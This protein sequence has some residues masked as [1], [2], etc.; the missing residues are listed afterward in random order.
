MPDFMLPEVQ[1]AAWTIVVFVLLAGLLWKFAWGP[2]LKA[3][4]ERED[5]ITKKLQDAEDKLKAAEARVADYERKIAGSKEEAAAIIAEGKRDVEKVRDEILAAAQ[6]E[7]AKTLERVKTEIRLAQEAAMQELRQKVSQWTAEIASKVIER[8]IKADD[9]R[10][11][12]DE[13]VSE[14]EKSAK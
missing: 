1:V 10:R 5:R 11:F 9:H 6:A 7:A 13:T 3:L 2:L 14:L 8:E 4:Q 12:I